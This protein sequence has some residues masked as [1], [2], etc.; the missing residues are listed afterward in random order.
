MHIRDLLLV[1]LFLAPGCAH[2]VDPMA[3][4]RRR[5]LQLADAVEKNDERR[6]DALSLRARGATSTLPAEG[7]AERRDAAAWLR[8]A[9]AGAMRATTEVRVSGALAT[10]VTLSRD[11]DGWRVEPE[12]L[13]AVTP[14]LVSAVEHLI[15]A[16]ERMQTDEALHLLSQPLRDTITGAAAERVRGLRTL[17]PTLDRDPRH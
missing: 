10:S 15:L 1:G 2:R 4:A 16:L 6:V 9:A 8:R 3:I 11:A 13:G 17:L 12:T 5:V 7:D 14:T